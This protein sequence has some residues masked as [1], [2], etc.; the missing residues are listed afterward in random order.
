MKSLFLLLFSALFII[1]HEATA[2]LRLSINPTAAASGGI[3]TIP[4]TIQNI[5][6]CGAFTAFFHYN[7]A[8]LTFQGIDTVGTLL[9]GSGV[10]VIDSNSTIRIAYFDFVP[11][12][13]SNA[14]LINIRFNF[15]GTP[16]AL[17]WNTAR[18]EFSIG[19]T[20]TIPVLENGRVFNAASSVNFTSQ[21]QDATVCELGTASFNIAATNAS[22]Y[23]W[24]ISNDSTGNGFTNISGATQ[25]TYNRPS[26]GIA[27][28]RKY[29]QCVVSDGSTQSLSGLAR[30]FVNPNNFVQVV[31]S[32][33]PNGAV[34]F[35]SSVTYAVTT[36]PAVANPIY[37]WT[38]NGQNVGSN[39]TFTS[40]S[41][42][43]GDIV[44]CQ[45]SSAS[46]CLAPSVT[47]VSSMSAMVN[48][49]P[50]IFT[51]SG[52]GARCADDNNTLSIQLSGSQNGTTYNLS[53]GGNTITSLSGTGTALTFSGLNQAGVY[54]I[55]AVSASGCLRN[56]SGSATI[57]VSPRP[58]FSLSA[59]ATTLSEGGNTQLGATLIAAATYSWTPNSNIIGANTRTPVVS[60]TQTTTYYCTVLNQ[61]TGCSAVDSITI[62]VLPAPIVNA[63]AD[64]AVCAS[65]PS[66]TLTGSPAGGTWSGV[67]VSGTTFTPPSSGGTFNLTYTVSQLGI[68]YSD[69]V[70]VTVN[71]L[72][73]VTLSS[74]NSVC[75]GSSSFSLSGG[76][77]A[78]GTYT[79]N[80]SSATTFNP[81]T[82]G[83]YTLVYRY[84]NSNGCSNSA[85]RTLVVN[86]TTP[87][88][89]TA[90]PRDS[91]NA[92]NSV[93]LSCTQLPLGTY[94]WSGS[95][96]NSTTS[97]VVIATPTQ[98]TTYNVVGT[99]LNGCPS[100]ASK[101]ITVLALPNV[102]AGV[103]TTLCAGSGAFVLSGNPTG[104]T[105]SGTGV[106]GNTF[107]PNTPGNY[108]ITYTINQLGTNFTD[109]RI[110]TVSANPTASLNAFAARC[111][112]DPAF[113]LTGGAPSGGTF[114]INGSP[115][116]SF[117][118][119][120][121]GTYLI[122]YSI[123]NASGCSGTAS[124][125]L[126]V[127]AKTTVNWPSLSDVSIL[128]PVVNLNATITPTGGVFSGTGVT[129]NGSIY[130]FDP[131]IAGGGT[132]ALTYTFIN[133]N[134]CTT[135]A[136]NNITVTIP[137]FNIWNGNGDW[138]TPSNWSLGT[139]TS[140]QNVNINSGTVNVNTNASVGKMFIATGA[141]VNIG[142]SPASGNS[143]SVSVADTL[144]NN[145][146]LNV[147]NPLSPINSVNE[148]HLVQ[149]P[150]S[151]LLGNGN[152]NFT[153]FSGN[154]ND[155][156][157]NYWSSPVQGATIAMLG[158][159]DPRNHYTYNASTG[160]IRPAMNS[161]M[162]AGIGYSSS[163][164]P[165][166]RVIFNASGNNRFHNGIINTTISGDTTLRGWNLVGN[167]Y[168]SSISASQFLSDNPNLFQAVWFWSQ[169]VA[170]TFPTGTLNGDYA[171]WN[172]TGGVAGSQGG[173]IPNGQIS[174]GQ[175]MFIKV[176]SNNSSLNSV[177][178]NN[179]QRT[180]S[181]ST[182]FRTQNFEK[183]WINL[184]GPNLAFNQTLIGF[185]APAT[186]AI[187]P[188]FDA[189][190]MRGND[191][192]ALYS[193]H[194]SSD[195]SIQALA[196]RTSTLERIG[197]GV[198]GSHAGIYELSLAQS[199]GFPS[200]TTIS[201]RDFATG[202][203]HNLANGPYSFNLAQSGIYRNRFELQFN[204]LASGLETQNISIL[205]ILLSNNKLHVTGLMEGESIIG[206]EI[207]DLTGKLVQSTSKFQNTNQHSLDLNVNQGVYFA[208]VTTS[209]QQ[210]VRKFL[211]Q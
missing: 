7:Q 28:D 5:S 1:G 138:S 190:K 210:I 209:K 98:T 31:V 195:M 15:N 163:G 94:A 83:S 127:N 80:G 55:S 6:N 17:I 76:S 34:C 137:S 150:N 46:E 116:T 25:S 63:G 81:T 196:G 154:S 198:D 141:T 113:S 65:G 148:H 48:S 124:Q 96:L 193:L 22:S 69:I 176:P 41:L 108:T 8:G 146:S 143:Y 57:L 35:G 115:S 130:E 186:A 185:G 54:S 142:S 88:T 134:G 136:T 53:M 77:P 13:S 73:T 177:N 194:G 104:G 90:S 79:V 109:N 4:V 107:T 149:G 75:A 11:L 52:G 49:L 36:T 183:A 85:T 120:T 172:L 173:A 197:L 191:R 42:I 110:I 56:M 33:S 91:V 87:I 203:L 179:G 59:G 118:P 19:S 139:P 37:N 12:N 129:L 171:V 23:Q 61:A 202:I 126:V 159:T 9:G 204:G 72:P 157:L 105:W 40:T 97:Q 155:T 184:T 189:E 99:N 3:V 78:G 180:N 166:G 106:S 103:D 192:I 86:P 151:I 140:G 160:W 50:T 174:A 82:S 207:I 16:S 14:T 178:F 133:G 145:G 205:N 45:V 84:T 123:T 181:N 44:A 24:Q 64:F 187:D 10:S 95:G 21:C 161:V 131:A 147:V 158:A 71:A 175:G 68:N 100:S 153:R 51:V 62:T 47:S 206:I 168:P 38:V 201:V 70:V 20:P 144:T 162:A 29:I 32:S 167:P 164:T 165:N 58:S 199:E 2:Q 132:F 200:A 182:V 135:T 208:R 117:N 156:I 102:N 67:G 27:D 60:P 152:Y 111:E 92:G 101:T 43:N 39:S 89:I 114:S 169:R 119:T 74:F 125:N 188:E 112:G 30:L 211:V 121:P 26:V 122:T 128:D 18:T 93:A 170:S 66:V